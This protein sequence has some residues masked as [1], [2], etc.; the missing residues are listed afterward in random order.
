ML[1]SGD[2]FYIDYEDKVVNILKDIQ[3]EDVIR[4]ELWIFCNVCSIFCGDILV[5]MVSYDYK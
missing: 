3:I 4:L 5:I 2:L 1:R